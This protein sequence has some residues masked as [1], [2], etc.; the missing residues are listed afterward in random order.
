MHLSVA[1]PG[2]TSWVP[3]E[4]VIVYLCPWVSVHASVIL[5]HCVGVSLCPGPGRSVCEETMNPSLGALPS[6]LLPRSPARPAAPPGSLPCLTS[7]S[8]L[9]SWGCLPSSPLESLSC[10]FCQG[11]G[12]RLGWSVAGAAQGPA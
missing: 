9:A 5:C 10:G 6:S 3:T 12:Q 2:A 8:C 4:D 7:L 11:P 1:S